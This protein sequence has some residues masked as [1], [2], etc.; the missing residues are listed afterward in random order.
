MEQRIDYIKLIMRHVILYIAFP[1]SLP[2]PPHTL[3][4]PPHAPLSPPA[5]PL[6]LPSPPPPIPPSSY[7]FSY[8][9]YPSTSG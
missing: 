4:L 7:S 1:I 5:P 9:F 6:P 8:S 2:L 3:T